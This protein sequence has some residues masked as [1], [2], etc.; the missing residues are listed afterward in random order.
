MELSEKQ[1]HAV[2]RCIGVIMDGNRR[3][4]RARG[5]L[6]IDGHA[7]GYEKMKDMLEWAR[8]AGITHV[9]LYAF[10]SENWNRSP[11]E[12][13]YLMKL[14]KRACVDE[15]DYFKKQNARIRI[16]GDRSRFSKDIIE[17]IQYAEEQTKNCTGETLVLAVS[18]GGREE[19]VEAAR[20]LCG[21]APSEI[22]KETFA[23]NLWTNGIPDPDLIIRTSGEQRLSGFLLWQAAYSELFFTETLW[24]DFTR[25]EFEKALMFF[26]S[27]KRN[28]GV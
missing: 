19:L 24:P 9:I 12:V 23:E 28:F 15:A 2:P 5:K 13:S 18:Y 20:K 26:A 6:S 7:A 14:L 25:A 11:E 1:T 10:S 22:T 21:K 4:A 27:T 17:A 3:W 16:I 8:E